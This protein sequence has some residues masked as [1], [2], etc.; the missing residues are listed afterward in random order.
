[1]E[2]TNTPLKSMC[3]HCYELYLLAADRSDKDRIMRLCSKKGHKACRHLGCSKCMLSVLKMRSII[4]SQCLRFGHSGVKVEGRRVVKACSECERK[5]I[6]HEELREHDER[7]CVGESC[8]ECTGR[9]RCSH[10]STTLQTRL[11]PIMYAGDEHLP[12]S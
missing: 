9:D 12:G 1:M 3:S 7:G 5:I 4:N 6:E 8:S 10:S 2:T 11:D